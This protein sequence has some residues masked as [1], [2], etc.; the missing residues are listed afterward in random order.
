MDRS[1]HGLRLQQKAQAI[2]FIVFWLL[3]SQTCAIQHLGEHT[4]HELLVRQQ[5]QQDCGVAALSMLLRRPYA[6]V[7]AVT[8]TALML[9]QG[10]LTDSD[11]FKMAE[12]LGQPLRGHLWAGARRPA[13]NLTGILR[14]SDRREGLRWSHYIYYHAGVVYDPANDM[15]E[16]YGFYAHNQPHQID[17]VLVRIRP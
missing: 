12:A 8:P 11:L 16:P 17:A 15:L 3:F 2:A 14:L 10:G 6:E 4:P 7:W 5:M 1:L 9:E 13:T